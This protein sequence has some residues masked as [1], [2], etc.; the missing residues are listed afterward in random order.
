MRTGFV[1]YDREEYSESIVQA[2]ELGFDYVEIMMDGDAHR[3]HLERDAEAVVDALETRDVDLLVHFPYPLLIGSPHRH[4]REGAIKELK[5][6]IEVAASVGAEKGVVHPDSY[7]WRRVWDRAELDSKLI[8]SVRELDE[9]ATERGLEICLENLFGEF[10][11]LDIHGFDAPLSETDVSMT[12]DT[13]HAAIAGMTE[14]EMASFLEEHSERV[15]HL[16]INDTRHSDHGYRG[17]DEHLPIGYGAL[18]FAEALQPVRDGTWDG[19]VSIELDT[20]DFE[21]LETSKRR[22]DRILE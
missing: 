15:S 10:N 20:E 3:D 14:A 7:G 22:L 11:S 21:Y 1:S 9:F 19:T 8:P 17:Q 16:H 13:G 2:D 6:C 4:Q 5:R 12:F 18:D